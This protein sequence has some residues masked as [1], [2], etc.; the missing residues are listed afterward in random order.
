MRKY[1][2]AE[3]A[4]IL[5]IS[6]TALRTYSGNFEDCGYEFEKNSQGHRFYSEKDVSVLRKFIDLKGN[7]NSRTRSETVKKTLDWEKSLTS[8]KDKKRRGA[9]S[10]SLDANEL[11]IIIEK[12][13]ENNSTLIRQNQEL[14]QELIKK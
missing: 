11:K 2:P 3:L 6:K 9:R 14:I 4:R 5:G 10:D 12:L 1:R 13:S 7:G 8:D